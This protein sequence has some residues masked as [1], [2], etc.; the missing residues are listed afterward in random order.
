MLKF[1]TQIG[2][3][4]QIISDK[5]TISAKTDSLKIEDN[6]FYGKPPRFFNQIDPLTRKETRFD[7]TNYLKYFLNVNNISYDNL[8]NKLMDNLTKSQKLYG[9]NY[10]LERENVST[11]TMTIYFNILSV[12]AN[13]SYS[14]N[15]EKMK[16][17]YK[18]FV[19]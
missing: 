19:S 3:F 1:S 16:Y 13:E 9:L 2:L 18:T 11:N 5:I 14:K 4:Q 15:N 6:K 10:M 8:L 7:E 12:M 17:L